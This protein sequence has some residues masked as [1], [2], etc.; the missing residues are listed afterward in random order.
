M[1]SQE[2]GVGWVVERHDNGLLL[3]ANVA[4]Q[5]F[6]KVAGQMSRV[7]LSKGHPQALPQL[8]N[9]GLSD[10]DHGQMTIAD[11]EVERA[12]PEPD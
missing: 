3:D 7:P 8:V 2:R 6:K 12:S 10:Q 9:G 1:V 5:T 11:M 4:V